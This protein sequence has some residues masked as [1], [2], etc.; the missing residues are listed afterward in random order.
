MTDLAAALRAP[1]ST[2][3]R[4]IDRLDAKQLLERFRSRGLKKIRKRR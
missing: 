1:L 4:I 3:T 2:V